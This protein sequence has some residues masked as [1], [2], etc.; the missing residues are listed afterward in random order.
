MNTRDILVAGG[1][2]IA[3]G[4]V[5]TLL[6]HP[7]EAAASSV[8]APVIVAGAEESPA[9]PTEFLGSMDPATGRVS[10]A[11]SRSSGSDTVE[12]RASVDPD[13][14]PATSGAIEGR[15]SMAST[16]FGSVPHFHIRIS[17]LA[18]PK[19]SH[20]TLDR[21][22]FDRLAP[23]AFAV[24]KTHTPR[25]RVED[26]PFSPYGYRVQIIATGCNGSS[27][28]ARI[29]SGSPEADVSLALTEPCT[30][31][32]RVRD[33]HMNPHAQWNLD[34][35]PVGDP[36]G[37]KVQLVQ[38]DRFGV[39]L[40]ERVVQ[41]DYDV[42]SDGRHLDTVT[43]QPLTI[44]RAGYPISIQS[45]TIVVPVGRRLRV[46]I[47]GPVSGLAETPL[48]LYKTD[49]VENRR[50]EVMTDF[51]G[52]FEFEHLEPGRYQLDVAR[53]GFQRTSRSVT[54]PEDAEPEPIRLRLAP[55]R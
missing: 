41:G 47:F 12:V 40:L 22:I 19:S 36:P 43:V 28:I 5:A 6:A 18:N 53:E 14:S 4:A 27:Q 8:D 23:R 38:T 37:R 32:V 34:L 1:V 30:F 17:E 33:Q 7:G 25:F 9:S 55:L 49:T 16:L 45:S 10:D 11:P 48:V 46:E 21:P 44:A 20:S 29:D 52:A 24:P 3:I 15:V 2:L 39:A 13:A 42:W 51:G 26:I 31:T 54:I 50:F 35:R